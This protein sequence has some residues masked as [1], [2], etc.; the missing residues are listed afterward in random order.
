MWFFTKITSRLL[1][2]PWQPSRPTTPPKQPSVVHIIPYS[3]QYTGPFPRFPAWTKVERPGFSTLSTGFST[4]K[5]PANYVNHCNFWAKGP[6]F[7]AYAGAK[8]CRL[9]WRAA[10][11]P[12]YAPFLHGAYRPLRPEPPPFPCPRAPLPSHSSRREG[13]FFP[14]AVHFTADILLD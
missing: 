8:A 14:A 7:L 3:A 12:A 1:C 13:I 10:H 5:S 6:P 2:P 4:G 11:S 9:A